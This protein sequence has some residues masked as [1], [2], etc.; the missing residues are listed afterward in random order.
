MQWVSSFVQ[1]GLK[2]EVHQG[3]QTPKSSH[4]RTIMVLAFIILVHMISKSL[5][6]DSRRVYTKVQ[7]EK[8][9]FYGLD[10]C[11]MNVTFLTS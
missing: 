8:V 6:F 3:L 7:Y 10:K 1:N 5:K 11:W 4:L 2:I 9:V